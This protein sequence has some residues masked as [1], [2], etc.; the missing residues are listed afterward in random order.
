MKTTYRIF[1]ID[2]KATAGVVDWPKEPGYDKIAA[3]IKPLL[4]GHD[5]EHVTVLH[6]GERRDMFVHDEGPLPALPPTDRATAI[7]RTNWMTQ[8]PSADPE[9]LP[10]IAGT[11]ILFDRRVWF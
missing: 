9:S 11:A 3:L 8:H 4:G 10:W 6:D 7:Y 5:L 2:G 1:R